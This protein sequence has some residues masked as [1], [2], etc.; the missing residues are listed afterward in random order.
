MK[1]PFGSPILASKSTEMSVNMKTKI[2]SASEI[3]SHPNRSL[4]PKDY[5]LD[6]TRPIC[7][8]CFYIDGDF[9]KLIK[10]TVDTKYS[11]A[12]QYYKTLRTIAKEKNISI[13]TATQKDNKES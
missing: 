4:S 6:E 11:S 10:D 1:I 7:P 3:A 12:C 2:V 9:C 5:I 13:I 8:T